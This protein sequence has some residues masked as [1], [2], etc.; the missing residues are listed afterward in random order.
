MGAIT[1]TQRHKLTHKKARTAAQKVA[2]RLAAEYDMESE[3]H[4]DVLHFKR[5]GVSGH[6]ALGEHSAKIE[7]HLGFLF[8]AFAGKIEDEVGRQMRKVF[9]PEE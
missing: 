4:G 7:I 1:I 5:S 2:D 6:L 9:G 3:W 8:M